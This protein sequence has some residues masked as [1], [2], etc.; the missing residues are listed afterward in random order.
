MVDI[1]VPTISVPFSARARSNG[2]PHGRYCGSN[3]FGTI[4]RSSSFEWYAS[5]SILWFQRFRY[6]SALEL[7]RMVCLMVDIVVPTISVPFSARA[8][9]NGMP[10]G[11]YCG[12]NDFGTIQR[13]SS[14]EWHA[15]RS[16]L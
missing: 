7:V 8:R 3:D 12:S 4:Q 6:H 1:V 16:I 11:R 13:S 10:Q 14:F 2:M 5:W 9:S 15:S